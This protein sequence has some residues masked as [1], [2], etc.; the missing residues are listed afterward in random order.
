M[1][2]WSKYTSAALSLSFAER[3]RK[4][5][6]WMEVLRPRETK[7]KPYLAVMQAWKARESVSLLSAQPTEILG[8]K[9]KLPRQRALGLEL[10]DPDKVGFQNE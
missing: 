2:A 3:H 7:V 9:L 8:T 6:A 1:S 10:V 5:L 4:Y